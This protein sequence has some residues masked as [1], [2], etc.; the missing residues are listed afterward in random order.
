VLATLAIAAALGRPHSTISCS[1]C[2][3]EIAGTRATVRGTLGPDRVDVTAYAARL[4]IGDAA[5]VHDVVVTAHGGAIVHA[6]AAG[7]LLGARLVACADVPRSLAQLRTVAIAWRVLGGSA[8]G[9][10]DLRA[11]TLAQGI[12]LRVERAT[13]EALGGTMDLSPVD[14]RAGAIATLHVHG[15]ELAR[16]LAL[17]T[18]S[19]VHGTGRLDGDVELRADAGGISLAHGALR[20]RNGGDM[21]IPTTREL[22]DA[23]AALA[24]FSYDRLSVGV[25][26][27]G[28]DPDSTLVIHG[29]AKK[30]QGGGPQELERT[31][32]IHGARA[33]VSH[34]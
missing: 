5:I 9:H 11:R 2:T 22:G 17:T 20:A 34:L 14:V 23:A 6:C 3:I 33:F 19:H 12:G 16:V 29:R 13:A 8:S 7:T 26:A 4:R 24:D 15:V 10:I 31:V 25:A 18:G 1:R 32:N 30:A 21:Q 28:S 27:N